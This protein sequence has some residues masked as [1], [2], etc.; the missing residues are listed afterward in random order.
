[1]STNLFQYK[2]LKQAITSWLIQENLS[3]AFWVA[4]PTGPA[5]ALIQTGP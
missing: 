4:Y 5:A 1:M 2:R 3:M